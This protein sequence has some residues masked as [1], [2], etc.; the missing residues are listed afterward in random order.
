MLHCDKKTKPKKGC[1]S[2]VLQRGVSTLEILIAMALIIL[3]ISYVIPL[4]S[5]AQ[6]SSVN[7][8]TNQEA[9]YKARDLLEEA[10]AIA[11][12]D[13]NL[14]NPKSPSQDDIY[15]K[16][17]EVEMVDLF[18]KKVSGYVTWNSNTSVNLTT[19]IT[20]PKSI[21]GGNTCSSVLS[22]NW[23]SPSKVEYVL[24]ADLPITSIKTFNKKMYVTVNNTS[25]NNANAFFVLD[26]SNPMSPSLIASLDNAPVSSGLNDVAIDG[27][28]YA[29]VANGYGAPFSTCSVEPSCSQLQ[30]IDLNTM[31]VV[32]NYKV[33]N[34]TGDGGQGVGNKVF[35]KD[36]VVYLG[37][38]KAG[39]ST[40]EFVIIDVG[41][42][43]KPLASPLNPILISS[44]EIDSGVNDI[45]VKDKYVYVASPDDQELKI[46]NT[47]D[48]TYPLLVGGFNAPDGGGSNGNG[49][50]LKLVG[51]KLYLGRTLLSGYEFYILD[52]SNPATNHMPPLGFKDIKN[53]ANSTSVN[54]III[55]DYLA[56]LITNE[57]LQI[58][59]INDPGS[60]TQY[61]NPLTLPS[62][63]QGTTADC[64]GNYIYVGSQGSDNKGYISIITG[65]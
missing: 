35:Y 32:T 1:E 57:E 39:G 60:I 36:V 3:V 25:S 58:W 26:I 40:G 14:V 29:Y 12:E 34:I 42:G 48:L 45:F 28:H 64:E 62:S 46:L 56:F 23:V 43:S 27:N 53:G 20:N 21:N 22:G 15:T 30:V 54:R 41:G 19:L 65:S 55:R 31:S 17:L 59:K 13:F 47:N 37:L 2:N 11:N 44:Y 51:N 38:A 4:S 18:I 33:P 7:T 16:S 9:L 49:K 52:N 10:R 6:D 63:S 8:Q 5:Q 24:G 61:A 50:S